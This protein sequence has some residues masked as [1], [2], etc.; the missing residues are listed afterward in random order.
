MSETTTPAATPA[1]T[2]APTSSRFS[3]WE[4]VVAVVVAAWT[5]VIAAVRFGPG[6]ERWRAETDAKQVTHQFYAWFDKG[7]F[8]PGEL[9]EQY[10]DIYNAPPLYKLLMG[11]LSTFIDPK[12]AAIGLSALLFVLTVA[13]IGHLGW[14]RG[15]IFVGAAAAILYAHAEGAFLSTVGGHPRSFGP[16]F[17]ALFLWTVV[18]K[19]RGLMLLLLVVEGGIYPSPLLACGPAAAIIVALDFWKDRRVKPVAAFLV[20]SVLALG[21]AKAQDL[22]AP[23]S[24]GRIISY[25]EAMKHPAWQRGSR[26]PYVPLP[27][28]WKHPEEAVNRLVAPVGKPVVTGVGGN[29]LLWVWA[30]LFAVALVSMIRRRRFEVGPELLLLSATLFAHLLARHLAFQLHI[31]HRAVAHG[32]PVILATL[33]PVAA[34]AGV[35]QLLSGW[36]AGLVAAVL[37]AV[38]LL[39][40]SGHGVRAP[41]TWRDYGRDADLYVWLQKKTPKDA[42]FAGNYQIM[43]EV[44]LFGRRRVYQNWKLAHP[45]RLGYFDLV[46]ERTRKMYEAFYA[47]DIKDIVR[48][49]DETGVDYMIVDQSRFKTFER[50]DGQLFEPLRSMVQPMF[51]ACTAGGCALNP[52][53]AKAVVFTSKRYQVVS[54]EKLRG[55]TSTST[56]TSTPTP[57][58]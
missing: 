29:T 32:W 14:R 43:D 53:P 34:W 42:L 57:T 41:R 8:P 9:L 6:F 46:T 26:F 49:A 24:W 7:T 51:S 15:G 25:D 1:A 33:V 23:T 10:A 47:R 30:G 18:E 58:P 37:T 31:P 38:P 12:D 36:K 45:Y 48:F 5:L 4:A 44:P 21:F 55:L 2:P 13:V 54:M 27:T 20:A 3:A 52:P 22:R 40:V 35:R 16:L 28:F 50:G 39:L 56:S 17:F 19:R 11:G